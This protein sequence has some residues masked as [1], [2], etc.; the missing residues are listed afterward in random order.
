[1]T[2]IIGCGGVSSG[3]DVLEFVEAGASAV[4]LYTFFGY[5]GVGAARKIKNDLEAELERIN[6]TFKTVVWERRQ[7]EVE[8]QKAASAHRGLA[9]RV[10]DGAEEVR[11]KVTAN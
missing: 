5:H 1:M 10:R 4:Q 7:R 8:N 3:A 11:E 9:E 2:P 6:K